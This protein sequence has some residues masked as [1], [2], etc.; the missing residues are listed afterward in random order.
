MGKKKKIKKSL[1]SY[2]KQKLLHQQKIKEIGNNKPHLKGYWEKE[3][4]EMDR[5]IIEA[6]RNLR[7]K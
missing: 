5:Q 7:E 1:E 2:E 4:E 6:K 3:I